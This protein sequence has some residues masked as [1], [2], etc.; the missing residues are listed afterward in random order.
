MC[1]F[2]R[3]PSGRS[4]VDY[5][6]VPQKASRPKRDG[7]GYL[8]MYAIIKTGGKQYRVAVGD[9]VKVELLGAEAGSQVTLNEVLAIGGEDGLKV[10]HPLVEG[11]SVKATVVSI[12]R[13]D[14]VRIFKFR[15]RKHSMK[16]G[17]HRQYYAEL[18][19]DEIAC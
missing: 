1:G 8:S 7:R 18:R 10:G 19:I 5:K 16:S 14:K 2:R 11:A 13:H 4:G 15:R 9:T 17:G 6:K 12:G 3:I